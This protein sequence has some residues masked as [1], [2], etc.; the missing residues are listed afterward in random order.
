MISIGKQLKEELKR[1]RRSVTWF[2]QELGYTRE[3]V[4]KL[5]QKKSLD[6][7]LLHR[8]NLILKC[9]LFDDYVEEAK[10]MI[11]QQKMKEAST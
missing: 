8:I 2:A 9:S 1:Q 11:D 4:Y 5:F 6:T 7:H 3:S 10:K